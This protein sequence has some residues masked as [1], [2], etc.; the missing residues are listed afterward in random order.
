MLNKIINHKFSKFTL[1]SIGNTALVWGITIFVVMFSDYWYFPT[2]VTLTTLIFLLNYFILTKYIFKV[3]KRMTKFFIGY[4][5]L[6]IL[7][8][9]LTYL[10]SEI[11]KLNYIISMIIAAGIIFIFRYLL[12]DKIIFKEVQMFEGGKK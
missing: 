3:E 8:L 7:T 6:Y 1:L 11:I 4:S 5:S 9:A 2:F 12:Y 10:F